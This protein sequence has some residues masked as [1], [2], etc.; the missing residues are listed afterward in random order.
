MKY[1]IYLFLVSISIG[2]FAQKAQENKKEEIESPITDPDK[3]EELDKHPEF[4][5]GIDKMMVYIYEN[6]GYPKAAIDKNIEGM[7]VISFVVEKDG[8]LSNISIF[9]DIGG[10]CG[11]EAARIVKSMPNWS[12]GILNGEKVRVSFNLPVRFKLNPPKAK[13]KKKRK[14]RN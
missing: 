9:R 10:G 12:P 3:M 6:I 2:S 1:L 4:P 13:K 7:V 5:G 11:P 14:R 8:S